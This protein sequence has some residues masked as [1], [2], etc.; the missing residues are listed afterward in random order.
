MFE[1]S[2]LGCLL[3][4]RTDHHKTELGEG[5]SGFADRA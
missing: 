2:E 3:D 5:K 1:A 4:L